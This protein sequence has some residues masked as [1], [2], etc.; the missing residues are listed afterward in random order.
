MKKLWN[1]HAVWLAGLLAVAFFV[2]LLGAG[3]DSVQS[4]PSLSQPVSASE[5][6]PFQDG[7]SMRVYWE[8]LDIIGDTPLDRLTDRQQEELAALG[9]S[10]EELPEFLENLR[11]F[12][13]E[14]D[15]DPSSG[16]TPSPRRNLLFL[17]GC[18]LLIPILLGAAAGLLVW[19]GKRFR[20]GKGR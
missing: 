3:A 12:L 16:Q 1:E 17:G 8:A 15:V 11:T 5:D 20:A 2:L 13:D 10:Q 4:A 7:P 9:V 6:N 18:V 19:F 14:E